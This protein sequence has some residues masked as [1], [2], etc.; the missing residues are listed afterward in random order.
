MSES[1][2]YNDESGR[3]RWD[4]RMERQKSDGHIW[5]GIFILAIGGLALA[6]S[7]GVP[8]PAW[9]FTWQ[10]LVIAIGLFIG[11]RK[12]FRDGGWF[13]P[14]IVGG[15]FLFNEFILEGDLRRHIWPMVLIVI[16]AFF[17][18]RP[19]SKR[20]RPLGKKN[21]LYCRNRNYHDTGW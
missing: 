2:N 12:G 20:C 3:D 14:V 6:K 11:F 7:M 13:I 19:R 4:N 8:M 5:T 10:M 18:F 17:I 15:F 9:L 1:T 21:R 16:G